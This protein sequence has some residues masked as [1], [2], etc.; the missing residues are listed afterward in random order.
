MSIN[1][2]VRHL[3]AFLMVAEEQSFTRAAERLHMTQPTLSVIIRD[4]E[5]A[6][7]LKLFDRTTRAVSL[8]LAGRYLLPDARRIVADLARS[9]DDIRS[10]SD[11]EQGSVKLAV[12]PSI[13]SSLV[14]QA[15]QQ[16]CAA[17]PGIDVQLSDTP[18]DG[19]VSALE[20]SAADL[21]IT[22]MTPQLARDYDV[23][24][25]TED[26]LVAVLPSAHPLAGNASLRWEMLAGEPLIAMRTGTSVRDLIDASGV[27]ERFGLNIRME[28]NYLSSAIS[29]THAGLGITILPSLGVDGIAGKA[30][31]VRPLLAPEITR[32]IAL[33]ERRDRWVPPA[34]EAFK[35]VLKE[36]TRAQ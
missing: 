15:L 22:V 26:A 29:L 30:L 1:V 2:D 27:I 20:S 25:L 16:F 32:T 18:A 7:D 19:I 14:P 13:A 28:A 31:Q 34:A 3:R 12:L 5:A 23:T 24:V 21:G 17:Y 6:L 36:L 8:T 33:L 11:L 9:L 35:S 4:L 10:I